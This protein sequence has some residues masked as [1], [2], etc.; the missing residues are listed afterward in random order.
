VKGS[1]T[2]CVRSEKGF[3]V[4]EMLGS[5]A[6]VV[7]THSVHCLFISTRGLINRIKVMKRKVG[8]REWALTFPLCVFCP[9]EGWARQAERLRLKVL[10]AGGKARRR[11]GQERSVCALLLS[12]SLALLL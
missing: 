2:S 10:L 4:L 6:W 3:G 7:G 9:G 5:K 11:Q 1:R 8:R 12:S